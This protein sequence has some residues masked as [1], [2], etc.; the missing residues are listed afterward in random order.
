MLTMYFST[1]LSHLL[2]TWICQSRPF[3]LIS[4]S[5][6][7]WPAKPGFIFRLLNHSSFQFQLLNTHCC[8]AKPLYPVIKSPIN[9]PFS[10]FISCNMTRLTFQAWEKAVLCFLSTSM[11]LLELKHHN[12]TQHSCRFRQ[13]DLCTLQQSL[14]FNSTFITRDYISP[15]SFSFRVYIMCLP[16]LTPNSFFSLTACFPREKRLYLQDKGISI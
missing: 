9:L 12:W 14:L 11:L 13:P 2:K 16:T 4:T 6:A 10:S 15:I 8:P 5:T 7:E 3:F 1:H